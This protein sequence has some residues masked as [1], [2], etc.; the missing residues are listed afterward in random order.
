MLISSYP[1]VCPHDCPSTCALL[2]DIE[3]DENVSKMGRVRGN[4]DHPYT[5][6]VICAKVARYAERHTHPDRLLKPL[7]R[8]DKTSDFTDISWESALDLIAERFTQSEQTGGSESVWPYHYAGTMGLVQR[9]SID[10]LRRAKGYSELHQTICINNSWTG[11]SAATGSLRGPDPCEMAKSDCVVIWGTNVVST[12]VNVMTHAV[13]ARKDRGAKIVAIDIY[14]TDTMKQADLPLLLRPGTDAALSCAVAHILFRDSHVDWDYLN[15]YSDFPKEFEKHLKHKTPE[16]ASAITGLSVDSIESFA[17]LIG[18]TPKTYFRLGYGFTRSRNGA[19][20]MHSAA[21]LPTLT[22]A[23]QHEGGGA[24]HCN[25]DIFGLNRDL[26]EGVSHKQDNI[27]VLDQSHIGA[28]LCNDP[29]ALR[30]GPPVTSMLIQ[31]TNPLSV[32]PDQSRVKEGFSRPDLFVAVHEHFMTET[33]Q[34]ANL[35]LPATMFVEHSDLYKGSGHFSIM[36]GGKLI[37]SPP[38][39]RSNLFVIESLAERLGVSHLS[40]FGLSADE[41]IDTILQSSGYGTLDQL[42]ESRWIHCQ[43]DF[44]KSHYL[45]GFG[46]SDGKFHFR[47]DWFNVPWGRPEVGLLGPT[48]DLPTFPDHCDII[49]SPDSDYPLRLATPPS[50]SFL[51]SSFT[52]TS[53]SQS[54]EGVPK[55]LLHPDTASTYDIANDSQV[56]LE[57][58]RGAVILTAKYFEGVLPNV[59]I[60]EGI[61]PNSSYIDG[62]GINTLIGSDSTA[63]HG[64]VGF[65]DTKVR[66]ESV[67]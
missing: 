10:R 39:C 34:V 14:E 3:S 49:E 21:C 66:I 36:Y 52:E 63:P 7:Y 1:S 2:V 37:D 6:G 67:S 13:K 22:G 53:S 64:G 15:K 65:H 27:R 42:K 56:R 31:N 11:F 4:P 55:V 33:A 23:W 50:R 57:N 62:C 45:D 25:S 32:A 8:A 17:R 28:V 54:R 59:L 12:Q 48:S 29:D 30:N 40:G 24:F 43:P 58:E 51:N 18:E 26:L 19:V 46:H 9:D 60:C 16:W 44:T 35:V 5:S 38:L 47:A 61:H 20:A 41:H